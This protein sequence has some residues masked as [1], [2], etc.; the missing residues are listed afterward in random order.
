MDRSGTALGWALQRRVCD[1]LVLSMPLVRTV[2]T[3][4]W[5]LATFAMRR[6]A[7]MSRLRV[8]TWRCPSPYL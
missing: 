8:M 3:V 2:G 6:A 4:V 5:T 1:I 7:V